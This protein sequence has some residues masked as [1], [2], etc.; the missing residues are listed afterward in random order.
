MADINDI[1]G[2]VKLPEKSVPLC[3]RAD[4]LAEFEDLDQQFKIARDNPAKT[5]GNKEAAEIAQVMQATREQMQAST[6]TFHLRALPRRQ[7][8]DLLKKHPS[9]SGE[10]G[11]F[12][13]DT[14]P[15]AAL[16]ACC[17]TPAM[18]EDQAGQLVDRVS[19]GQWNT[20]WLAII[21]LNIGAAEVPTS[22]SASAVLSAMP[23]S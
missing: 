16:A 23:R 19:Q 14:F 17:V 4:L 18:S 20:L 10:T 22:V 15:V 1:L 6:E 12:D 11:E 7:W 8:S 2:Q 5:L 9:A 3:L 13:P 21:E